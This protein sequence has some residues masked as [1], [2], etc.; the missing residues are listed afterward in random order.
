MGLCGL[1]MAW[2]P[3]I[4]NLLSDTQQYFHGEEGFDLALILAWRSLA[5]S[6]FVKWDAIVNTKSFQAEEMDAWDCVEQ[7]LLMEDD[8]HI[9]RDD[10]SVHVEDNNQS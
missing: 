8:D 10:L 3:Q 4:L 1:R 6:I 9:L 7:D 5:E 2:H